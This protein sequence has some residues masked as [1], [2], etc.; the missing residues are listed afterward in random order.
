M[1]RISD[2]LHTMHGLIVPILLCLLG[3]GSSEVEFNQQ[4]LML[5]KSM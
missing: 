3:F 4:N 2:F 1:G 5:L